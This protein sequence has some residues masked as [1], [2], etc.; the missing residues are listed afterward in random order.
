VRSGPRADGRQRTVR[1]LH[2]IAADLMT[3]PYPSGA[4]VILLGHILHD[5]SDERAAA[6][7]ATSAALPTEAGSSASQCSKTT[8]PAGSSPM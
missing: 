1:P 3:G 5:W 7:C 4:D 8:S 6:S 2:A